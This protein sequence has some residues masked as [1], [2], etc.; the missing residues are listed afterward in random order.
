M[1]DWKETARDL[2]FILFV[3]VWVVGCYT[4]ERAHI[5]HEGE[6]GVRP[7]HRELIGRRCALLQQVTAMLAVDRH[8]SET[9]HI[10]Y[11]SI[12]VMFPHD[13]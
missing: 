2:L 11:A 9:S 13:S 4:H 8:P 3:R 12:T 1:T 6:A 10:M 5:Q 7:A